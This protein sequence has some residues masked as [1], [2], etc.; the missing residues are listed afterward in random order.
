MEKSKDTKQRLFEM[1]SRID[2]SFKL[3]EDYNDFSNVDNDDDDE[4]KFLEGFAQQHG[5]TIKP[6]SY[7]FQGIENERSGYDLI[8]DKRQIQMS[9]EPYN[10]DYYDDKWLVVDKT[11]SN[12]IPGGIKHLKSLKELPKVFPNFKP[13]DFTGFSLK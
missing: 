11:K 8:N 5:L 13:K 7:T 10:N 2:K 9:I 1:M 3:N 4:L 12:G 6:I